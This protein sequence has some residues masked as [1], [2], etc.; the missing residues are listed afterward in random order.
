MSELLAAL[1]RAYEAV[2]LRI[3]AGTRWLGLHSKVIEARERIAQDLAFSDEDI[4]DDSEVR[5]PRW[6]KKK[7]PTAEARHGSE[8]VMPIPRYQR[9]YSF[10]CAPLNVHSRQ[11][12]RPAHSRCLI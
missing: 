10:R 6:E 5:S 4:D 3:D 9:L 12:S 7:P 2:T 11:F 1:L 8:T